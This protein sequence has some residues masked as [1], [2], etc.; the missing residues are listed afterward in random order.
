MAIRRDILDVRRRDNKWQTI[1]IT[2]GLGLILA[3]CGWM[4]GGIFGLILALCLVILTVLVTPRIAPQLIFRYYKARLLTPESSPGL[5]Q[6]LLSLTKRAGLVNVPKLYYIPSPMQNA[7][8]TG[9]DDK[10]AIGITDG[11]LKVFSARE[12]AGILA[13]E[14]SHI[15]HRD[16]VVMALAD[17]MNRL[18]AGA[19]QMV[20]LLFII[21]V[22]LVL[23]GGYQIA[24]IPL[25]LLLAAPPA[26]NILQLGL[27]R[28]REYAADLEAARLTGDPQGLASAL[29]KLERL[30]A[31]RWEQVL[32]PGRRI[33]EPS[34]LRTH[35]P[36]EERV[37]RLLELQPEATPLPQVPETWQP[38][39]RQSRPS[40]APPVAFAN[41]R[42]SWHLSGLWY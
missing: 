12:V 1:A 28:T 5:Y 15:K 37:A 33:P 38:Y 18:T 6:I 2:L 31:G 25:L 29:R 8:A 7:F 11:I 17:T 26:G 13:H 24:W 9:V 20:I 23:F 16:T 34:L 41:R 10:A 19:S 27:S 3:F 36:T 22:P 39:P 40:W 21:S 30:S 4:I 35:P 14:I 32:L 42:P